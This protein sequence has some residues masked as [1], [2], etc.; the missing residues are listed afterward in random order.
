MTGGRAV[1]QSSLMIHRLIFNASNLQ[2]TVAET[3][4]SLTP[5]G[6]LFIPLQNCRAFFR[7]CKYLQTDALRVLPAGRPVRR[8]FVATSCSSF[9]R[10]ARQ[11]WTVAA[12]HH[13][14]QR[15]IV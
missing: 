9:F 3:S 7:C 1:R 5:D 11:A 10:S 14:G 12:L 2:A 4:V 6:T 15:G 8:L 13:A